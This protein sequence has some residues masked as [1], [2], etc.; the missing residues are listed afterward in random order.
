MSGFSRLYDSRDAA[1]I[2]TRIKQLGVALAID[3]DDESQVR[4]LA[5]EALFHSQEALQQ[6]SQHPQD[7]RQRAK[8]ELFGL[9]ALMMQ[10]MADSAEGGMHTHGGAAWKAFSRALLHESGL[11]DQKDSS[12][13]R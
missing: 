10:T 13:R 11:L 3:W 9:A 4:M 7:Y 2:E 1:E 12:S 8:T 5:R 6:S